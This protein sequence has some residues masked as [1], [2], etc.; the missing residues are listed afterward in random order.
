[1][2]CKAG[3]GEASLQRR[4]GDWKTAP[5]SF[6]ISI[7]LV[8]ITEWRYYW[9]Y[10]CIWLYNYTRRVCVHAFWSWRWSCLKLIDI[11][12]CWFV[13]V[14]TCFNQQ[15]GADMAPL[16]PIGPHW[17]PFGPTGPV[18]RRALAEWAVGQ[19]FE[20]PEFRDFADVAVW[21]GEGLREAELGWGCGQR[22]WELIDVKIG[23]VK[24]TNDQLNVMRFPF[25][26]FW[27]SKGADPMHSW[28]CH[29]G[30]CVKLP[31]IGPAQVLCPWQSARISIDLLSFASGYRPKKLLVSWLWSFAGISTWH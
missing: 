6:N 4:W 15:A 12:W 10:H 11:N 9:F 30:D 19:R 3:F 1:M 16:G 26:G 18:A 5:R 21:S 23:T 22:R 13:D 20:G 29:F 17:A 8:G 7:I 31:R 27:W 24:W 2:P 28:G 25:W 14:L